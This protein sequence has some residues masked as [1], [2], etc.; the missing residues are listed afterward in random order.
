MALPADTLYPN[1]LLYP[2]SADADATMFD[3]L[4]LTSATTELKT[5]SLTVNTSV[6][7]YG[8]NERLSE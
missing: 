2:C 8:G 3:Y 4:H 7:F 1:D 5:A 6:E